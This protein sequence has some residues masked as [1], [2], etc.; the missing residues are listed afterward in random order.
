MTERVELT[1]STVPDLRG[2]A[3]LVLG[4]VGTRLDLSYERVDDLQIAVL[5]ALEAVSE[6][7]VTV[8]VDV[9]DE[10][11]SVVLGPLD[12]E[13]GSDPALARVLGKLVDGVE[14]VL[15]DGQPWIALRLA[16]PPATSG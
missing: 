2:V 4:G 5:S 13:V 16:R 14:D 7:R 3:S 10:R 8:E 6:P 1:L 11:L 15:R 12:R 9:D